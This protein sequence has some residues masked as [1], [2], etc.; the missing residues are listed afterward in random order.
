M[1]HSF[2][3]P[4]PDDAKKPQMSSDITEDESDNLTSDQ[5]EDALGDVAAPEDDRGGD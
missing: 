4:N 5:I 2:R 3:I 1:E